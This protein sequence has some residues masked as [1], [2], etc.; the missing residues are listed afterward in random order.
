M[1]E[2]EKRVSRHTSGG[3]LWLCKQ[4]LLLQLICQESES[5]KAG[6]ERLWAA[7]GGGGGGGYG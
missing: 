6:V 1:K 3:C 4:V 7:T 2:E 5:L